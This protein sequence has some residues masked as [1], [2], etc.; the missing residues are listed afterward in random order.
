MAVTYAVAR[1]PEAPARVA[2]PDDL[3]TLERLLDEVLREQGGEELIAALAEIRG[4]VGAVRSGGIDPSI[5]L[6]RAL[7]QLDSP[8]R[9]VRACTMQ[10]AMANVASL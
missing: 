4:A 2:A 8:L 6:R 3:A 9:L 7:G 1:Q 5:T 10:L